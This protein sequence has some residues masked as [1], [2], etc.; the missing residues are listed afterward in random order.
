[1]NPEPLADFIDL[2]VI[3]EAEEALP[4]L[5]G[6]Y[7]AHRQARFDRQA[8]LRAAADIGGVYVPSL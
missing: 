4:E 3:G 1:M 8:F 5:I 6:L 2:F 7:R